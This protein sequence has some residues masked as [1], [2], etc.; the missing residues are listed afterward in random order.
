MPTLELADAGAALAHGWQKPV[1]AQHMRD[2]LLRVRV[3]RPNCIG[4]VLEC[5]L[6]VDRAIRQGMDP[7]AKLVEQRQDVVVAPE[8]GVV[9][10]LPEVL[11][12]AR[13]RVG[14]GSAEARRAGEGL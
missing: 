10:I 7:N 1:D 9:Q 11:E 2:H 13:H 5:P 3:E 14:R 8:P 6:A 4:E 12:G